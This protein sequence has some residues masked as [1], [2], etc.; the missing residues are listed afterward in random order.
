MVDE[1]TSDIT[2]GVKHYDNFSA[3]KNIVGRIAWSPDGKMFALPFTDGTIGLWHFKDKQ[4]YKSLVGHKRSVNEVSWSP[5]GTRIVSGANGNALWVWDIESEQYH[6]LPDHHT[7]DIYTVA[8]SANGELIASSGQDRVINI[9][10]AKTY[11]LIEKYQCNSLIYKIAF[12]PDSE[13]I[14][15]GAYDGNVTIWDVKTHTEVKTINHEHGAVY[16]VAWSPNGQKLASASRGRTIK[17]WHRDKPNLVDVLKKHTTGIFSISFSPDN[18]LFSS[19]SFDGSIWIWRCDSLKPITHFQDLA[20]KNWLPNICFHPSELI[21]AT[22]N[23]EQQI[24]K[25][26]QIDIKLLLNATEI[27]PTIQYVNAK[28]VLVGNS[29]VGKTGLSLS[30]AGEPYQPTSP[31]HNAS[32]RVIPVPSSVAENA[33]ITLWDLP[34]QKYYHIIHQLFLGNTQVALLL[35]DSLTQSNSLS[36]VLYW[37]KVLDKQAPSTLIKYLVSSRYDLNPKI[38]NRTKIDELR[39]RYKLRE[40]LL[41]SAATGEGVK[42]LLEKIQMDIPWEKLPRINQPEQFQAIVDLILNRKVF[43]GV[44]VSMQEFLQQVKHHAIKISQKDLDTAIYHLQ[45]EGKVHRINFSQGEETLLLNPML[46]CECASLI[47]HKA[48]EFH[49]FAAISERD[50][51]SYRQ[52]S[53]S[54][55]FQNISE[56][57]LLLE[58]TIEMLIQRDLCFR[59]MGMLIFPSEYEHCNSRPKNLDSDCVKEVSYEF[60]GNVEAIYSSLIIRLIKTDHFQREALWKDGA[61]FLCDA[62]P[63]GINRKTLEEGTELLDIYFHNNI[64]KIDRA[65]FVYQIADRLLNLGCEFK[66]YFHFYCTQCHSYLGQ[67]QPQV[68]VN[69][70]TLFCRNCFL[71]TEI[72]SPKNVKEFYGESLD[73][74]AEKFTRKAEEMQIKSAKEFR[75]QIKTN[76]SRKDRRLQILH[77]SDL[78]ICKIDEVEPHLT[79]L[80]VDLKKELNIQQLDYLVISGDITKYSTP[81]EYNAAY[82]LVDG[83]C[84]NFSLDPTRVIIAPGNHDFNWDLSAEAYRYIPKHKLSEPLENADKYIIV[85]DIGALRQ[86]DEI[87]KNRFANFAYFYKK[88]C[89]KDYP[90]NSLEQAILHFHNEDSLIFLTLNSSWQADHYYHKRISI[91]QNAL[92]KATEKL[93]NSQYDHWLKIAVWHHPINSNN[94]T[95]SISNPKILELLV[96]TK[97]EI[98]L[99]GHVHEEKNNLFNYNYLGLHVIG[100]GTFGTPFEERPQKV[101]LHYNLILYDPATR[102][103]NVENRKKEKPQGKWVADVRWKNNNN[104]ISSKYTIELPSFAVNKPTNKNK[105]KPFIDLRT[106]MHELITSLDELNIVAHDV[107]T[108]LDNLSGE[109][110]EQKCFYLID[111]CRKQSLVLRLIDILRKKFPRNEFLKNWKV[112]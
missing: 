112:I 46:I 111:Y 31:S 81:D 43:P 22:I 47:I 82:S 29:G 44:F 76:L 64:N 73:K 36:G 32:F 62:K 45:A 103:I 99:H 105:N 38:I 58:A 51:F 93:K 109:S 88:T 107:G 19:K 33:K 27:H 92:T 101:P 63:L 40:H 13:L 21:L 53:V 48:L 85:H 16:S 42:G 18:R 69:T 91:D 61:D 95:V 74:K 86:D 75:D 24:I 41:T 28:V 110:L 104:D 12:S 72:K 83:L 50:L 84:N 23:E 54:S 79:G 7:E 3:Q 8:W 100:A 80:E 65:I 56:E 11:K 39:T 10:D 55:H 57:K 25:L 34:G 77:L 98:C 102:K 106:K 108:R 2:P 89:G 78:H 20:S 96:Q 52:F 87:Y 5:D 15:S 37:A 90:L 14:A 97:F 30:L 9:W 1:S 67:T 49:S 6:K 66:E 71:S 59:E 4:I 60:S 35:F 68:Y 26:W 17:I 94:D 70:I